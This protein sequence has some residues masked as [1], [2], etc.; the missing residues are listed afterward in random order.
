MAFGSLAFRPELEAGK[1][2]FLL[3]PIFHIPSGCRSLIPRYDADFYP[4]G[5]ERIVT[6]SCPQNYKFTGKE[7]DA[8]LGLDNFEA[9]YTSSSIGRFA[10]PDPFGG[11]QQDPQTLNEYAYVRN[12]PLNL[13]DPT[14]LDLY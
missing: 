13:T 3:R 4:F 2:G 5:G 1:N 6:N 14:G 10:S 11:H 9:R 8:E 7:R 12:N